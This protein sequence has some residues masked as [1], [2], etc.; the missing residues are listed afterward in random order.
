MTDKELEKKIY[1]MSPAEKIDFLRQRRGEM[2]WEWWQKQ[3]EPMYED[4]SRIA[5]LMAQKDVET[6][7]KPEQPARE[8]V[9]YDRPE[10]ENIWEVLRSRDCRYHMKFD[11]FIPNE[12]DVDIVYMKIIEAA[13]KIIKEYWDKAL[14]ANPVIEKVPNDKQ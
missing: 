2:R 6:A 8:C 3:N 5:G 1:E 14:V 13:D 7:A 10:G 4:L 11:V 9:C 12:N